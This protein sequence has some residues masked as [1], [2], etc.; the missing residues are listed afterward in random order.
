MAKQKHSRRNK[1]RKNKGQVREFAASRPSRLNDL[2]KNQSR[3][4]ADLA[5]KLAGRSLM[6]QARYLEENNDV[7]VGLLDRLADKIVGQGISVEPR[8]RMKNGKP[9]TSL[10]EDLKALRSF[11][12]VSPEVTRE[13]S[14]S[15]A[16]HL[17]CGTWLRDGEMFN[18]FIYGGDDLEHV[19]DL[20][21]SFQMIESELCPMDYNQ[22]SIV[23]GIKKNKWAKPKSYFF[24]KDSKLLKR[25]F[26]ELSFDEIA[27]LK[28]TRR[29]NQT[30]GQSILH[31]VLKRLRDIDDIETSERYALRMAAAM[32]AYIKRDPQMR[33]NETT[34]QRSYEFRPGMVWDDLKPGEDVGMISTDRPNPNLMQF[35]SGQYRGIGLGTRG[36]YSDVANHYDGSFSAQRQELVTSWQGTVVLQDKFIRG[37]EAP[38]NK[39]FVNSSV[40]SGAIRLPRDVD[41]RTLEWADYGCPVMPWIDPV[42]E[43]NGEKIAVEAGFKS[44]SSVVRGRSHNPNEVYAEIQSEREQAKTDGLCFSSDF[45]HSAKN[46]V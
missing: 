9:Y 38:K 30:R 6:W 7:V 20:P 46:M 1:R 40:L 17:A 4:N 19:E 34:Q 25:D 16:A 37:H 13:H 36:S 39:F 29:I 26:L 8:I 45:G 5:M 15:T 10:N 41:L 44:R 24:Y 42:K 32:G 11:W 18:R 12:A 28:F 43:W 21:F 14:E 31:A 27:H 22:D 3:G 23:Q 35:I 2:A 33:V